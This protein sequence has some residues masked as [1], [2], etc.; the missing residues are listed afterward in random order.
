MNSMVVGASWHFFVLCPV[1]WRGSRRTRWKRTE[2][3][4][5]KETL[6]GRTSKQEGKK[7]PAQA[8]LHRAQAI[9]GR[10]EEERRNAPKAPPAQVTTTSN[11]A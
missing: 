4:G 6:A 7:E 9:G 1:S 11:T 8:Q 3:D 2:K 10:I 5:K